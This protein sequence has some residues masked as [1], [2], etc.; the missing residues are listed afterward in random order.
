MI[1]RRTPQ[2]TAPGT[3][4]NT[5]PGYPW[6]TPAAYPWSRPRDLRRPLKDLERTPAT[7]ARPRRPEQGPE[8]RLTRALR[9]SCRM[10]GPRCQTKCMLDGRVSL[11]HSQSASDIQGPG[12]APL[13]MSRR[14]ENWGELRGIH[15]PGD[16]PAGDPGRTPGGVPGG[17][18]PPWV[19]PGY[20]FGYP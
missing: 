13:D 3:A 19:P 10:P 12:R 2:D 16:T 4:R 6:A 17:T 20:P 14:K 11:T 9:G 18:P 7:R 8:D 15:Q 1:P 5:H